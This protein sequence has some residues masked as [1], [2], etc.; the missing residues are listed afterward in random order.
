MKTRCTNL[1]EGSNIR[2]GVVVATLLG[3]GVVPP[4]W[5][6]PQTV[7]DP[8]FQSHDRLTLTI[9]APLGTIFR[10]R[11]QESS[12]H[13]AVLIVGDSSGA[14]T[15][16][17]IQLKTR[18][19][20]R[21][22]RS[23]CAFPPLRVRFPRDRTAGTVFRGQDRL[24]LVT[25]CQN[26][27]E[28]EQYVVLEYLIYRTFN[29]FTEASFRVRGAQ[30]TYVDTGAGG[31]RVTKQAFFIEEEERMA[32]R[33]GWEILRVPGV[34]PQE[35]DPLQMSLVDV[36]QYMIGHTDY[37]AFVSES[38][39]DECCHNVKLIGTPAG[40]VLPVPYDFDGS[41]VVSARYA[42]PDRRFGRR[43]VR[44]RVFRG[45]CL[46]RE[47]VA[48]VLPIFRE[49]QEDVYSLYRAESALQANV[50][51]RTLDYFDDFYVVLAD[52]KKVDREFMKSCRAFE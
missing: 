29:L 16:L 47:S 52:S 9:E 20:N 24:K 39:R 18:G 6:S 27:R 35:V 11:E 21:L 23:V 46:F 28:Y 19:N 17:D 25:H 48:E 15:R 22:Q 12:Y 3:L 51:E 40:P 49:R 1:R 4:S 41:G 2:R 42:V 14:V 43:S 32:A 5:C 50:I 31:K 38:G 26:R 13:P 37:S 45:G 7:E 44:D 33:N 8:L 36:F 10:E 34:A 30:I